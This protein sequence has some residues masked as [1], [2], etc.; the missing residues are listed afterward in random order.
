MLTDNGGGNGYWYDNNSI[1]SGGLGWIVN[2]NYNT[3]TTI[4]LNPRFVSTTCAPASTNTISFMKYVSASTYGVIDITFNNLSDFNAYYDSFLLV[5]TGTSATSCVGAFSGTPYDNTDLKYYRYY[6]LAI[7]TNTG[8]SV[9]GSDGSSTRDFIIHPSTQVTTGFT[10]SLYTLRF[11]MPKVTKGLFTTPGCVLDINISNI[12]L[13]IN[14]SSLGGNYTGTTTSGSRYT[15][16]FHYNY[17]LCSG[18]TSVTTASTINGYVVNPQYHNETI[19]YTGTTPTIVPS[20]SAKT[21]NYDITK[22]TYQPSSNNL[23]YYERYMYYYNIRSRN[24]ADMR[25][26][27][28]FASTFTGIT[29]GSETLIYS[30]TGSTSAGTIYDNSYFI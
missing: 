16:P 29:L 25:D 30:Y 13:I 2:F 19:V 26:F 23:G 12:V 28:I 21:F 3:I 20:L 15:F 11:T 17:A 9:C 27:D 1:F 4:G 22:Y 6:V 7:P 5:S 8:S 14:N 18:T 24:T 10:G